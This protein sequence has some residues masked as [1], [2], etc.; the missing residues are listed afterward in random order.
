MGVGL[1]CEIVIERHW[2]ATGRSKTSRRKQGG[3]RDSLS[4]GR[5]EG[6][7]HEGIRDVGRAD[8]FTPTAPLERYKRLLSSLFPC[9]YGWRWVYPGLV[10]IR[11][12]VDNDDEKYYLVTVAGA[13]G[14]SGSRWVSLE[15]IAIKSTR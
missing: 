15:L 11:S 3:L 1:T 5:L 9:N 14:G 13:L 4:S 6:I 2:T 8:R 12:F 7:F 10:E